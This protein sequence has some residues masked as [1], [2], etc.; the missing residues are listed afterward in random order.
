MIFQVVLC[1]CLEEQRHFYT[2]SSHADTWHDCVVFP[3]LDLGEKYDVQHVI[4]DSHFMTLSRKTPCRDA[5]LRIYL[6][7]P[8]YHQRQTTAS[9][10]IADL[11]S[12]L[13]F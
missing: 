13:Y 5:Q 9:A 12:D 6:S 4:D 3:L 10:E 8:S 7:L 1:L 11:S 2:P